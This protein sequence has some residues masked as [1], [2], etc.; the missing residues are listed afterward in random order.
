M[1]NAR[2]VIY[3]VHPVG[4]IFNIP[5][6]PGLIN[7]VASLAQVDV[8]LL[9]V[10]NSSAPAGQFDQRVRVA[11]YPIT[12]HARHERF[13]TLGIGYLLFGI[14]CLWKRR[15]Q[16]IL[17]IGLRGLIVGGLLAAIFR[18]KLVYN[19]LEIYPARA[20]TGFMGSLAHR[21]EAYLNA[22]AVATV[23]QDEQRSALLARVN[24]LRCHR[25]VYFPN[26]P[27]VSRDAPDPMG[28]ENF[29]MSRGIPINKRILLYS[30]GLYAGVGLE[31]LLLGLEKLGDDWL[32]I[33]QSH[34]GILQLDRAVVDAMVAAG[35][36]LVLQEPLEARAY[37]VLV[38]GCDIG[39][40]W[41]STSDENMKYVGL[42][43]G[44]VGAYW[45]KGKPIIINRIPFFDVVCEEYNS[46][47]AVRSMEDVL[48]G[49]RVIVS[50]YEKYSRGSSF[51]YKKYFDAEKGRQELQGVFV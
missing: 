16:Y 49:I 23:I 20:T 47:V 39:L 17:A 9:G 41:Y 40:A 3:A 22:R 24:G 46:G 50:D 19:C 26:Y 27:L 44:K 34:D 21:I 31:R 2:K 42:S 35:R 36:L 4:Q 12:Q 15:P 13:A 14:F 38:E 32:V 5:C 43:S 7:A 1:K 11:W 25:F 8:C 30:G 6:V 28:V 10:K 48:E 51:C 37:E 45:S 33:L 29:K 18:A